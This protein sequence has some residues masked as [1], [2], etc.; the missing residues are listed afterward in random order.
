[1]LYPTLYRFREKK[2]VKMTWIGWAGVSSDEVTEEDRFQIRELLK[3]NDCVPI[4]YEKKLLDDFVYYFE[5]ILY[6]MFHS[7]KGLNDSK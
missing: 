3:Q 5:T 6:P 4:F 7:F 1:L 2:L